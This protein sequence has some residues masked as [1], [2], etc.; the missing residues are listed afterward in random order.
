MLTKQEILNFINTD[1]A[2]T[3]KF[4]AREGQRYYEGDHDIRN[5]R[6]F[7]FD[8]NGEL[9]EDKTKSNIK[10]S[11]PFFTELVDQEVQYM[12]SGKNAFVKSDDKKLQSLLDDRFNYNED[13][14]S[15]L[16]E[17]LTGAV[18]KGFE[19]MY[20]YKDFENHLRFQCANSLG[21]VEVDGKYSADGEDYVIYYYTEYVGA[22]HKAIKRVQ[23]WNKYETW[24]LFSEKEGELIEEPW[25]A[26]RPNPRPHILY[27]KEDDNAIYFDS[28]G[29]IPFFRL[30][31]NENKIS[32]LKP[33][34]AIID[35]Y[36]LMSCGLSNNIQDANEYLV[37]VKGFQG[38]NMEE[39]MQNIRTKK[40]I[41]VPGGEGGGDVEFKTVSIPTDARKVKLDLDESNIYRFGMGFN[42]N[43]VGD[44][45]IT[46]IV[47][48]SRYALLDLKCNKLEIR[49]KKFMRTILNLVLDEIN[50]EEN[51]DYRSSEVYFDFEREIMTNALDNATIEKTDAEKQ[52]IAI[53]TLLSLESTLGNEL[54][55]E[56]ICG[57][58]DLDYKEIKSQLP[59]PDDELKS[60][61][62]KV[63]NIEQETSTSNGSTVEGGTINA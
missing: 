59:D 1:A 4:H 9:Q 51:T 53:N 60:A 41:G 33:I 54:I 5:Y 11:H 3:L 20:A 61:I 28:L 57:V 38:D 7:Y 34:K 13:F 26:E 49:L 52:Q 17:L 2:S 29:Y 42:S 24:Y 55:V 8:S 25:K 43:Q 16:Y 10:I 27:Q 50:A 19:Y 39:L 31:N 22:D 56:Q 32:G 47:I 45:N 62:N 37:V 14:L 35:D 58:L 23:V 21:V 63:R 18:S 44:G 6:L 36:D 48:K 12:L 40:H 15:E 46:N 30:D